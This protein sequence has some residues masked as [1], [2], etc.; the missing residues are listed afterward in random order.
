MSRQPLQEAWTIDWLNSELAINLGLAIDCSTHESYMSAPNSYITFCHIYGFDIEPSQ[1]TLAYYVTF[2]SSHINPRSIDSYL[3]GVCN[4]LESH[5]PDVWNT[6]KSPMVSWVL[7]GAKCHFG[8]TTAY[9]L[10]LTIGNLNTV[11]AALGTTPSHNNTLFIA[12]LFTGF[13]NLLCLGELCR[14]DKVAL[15]DYCKVTMW[16]TIDIFENYIGLLLPAHKGNAFFKGNCLIIW[17]SSTKAFDLFTQYLTS[18]EQNFQAHP[19]LWLCSDGTISTHS[20]FIMQLHAFFPKS[21]GGQSM[22]VGGATV[23]AE[24]GVALALIQAAGRWSLDTFN[25]YIQKM[26]SSSRPCSLANHLHY[27][28]SILKPAFLKAHLKHTHSHQL[29]LFS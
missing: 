24:V 10:P 9:K 12:Q 13:E 4:Q 11:F 22:Y 5:F 3:S 15:C 29:C 26:F 25:Q 16:Y 17:Y 19:K 7:K 20:W 27:K 2:Q 28:Q 8:R 1:Q 18:W 21:I 23:L 14:P 6:H